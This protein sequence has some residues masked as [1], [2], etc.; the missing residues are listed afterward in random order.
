VITSARPT[1]IVAL[2]DSITHA[3]QGRNSYRRDLWNQLVEAGYLIDFV[4]TQSTTQ[5]GTPFPDVTFDPDHD[6][7]WGWRTDEVLN[8]RN[9]QLE[10]G[11]LAD[12]LTHYT[13][14]AALVHLGSNDV[15][16]GNSSDGT[17]E[18]LRQVIQTLRA[19][20]PKVV[21]FLA[22]IIPSLN[23]DQTISS[24]TR[25]ER[26]IELNNLIP[27]LVESENSAESPVILVDQ[28]TG[29][30]AITDTYDGI[31]PNEV[32]EAKM[33]ANW[34]AALS[35]Y[36]DSLE[37]LSGLTIYVDRRGVVV[38]N[39]F[40]AGQLYSGTLTSNTDGTANPD[41]VIRG[42][43]GDDII[44]GGM[45]GNDIIDAGDG[46]N[47]IDY[48]KGTNTIT[49]GDG[50]NT[51]Y[52]SSGGGRL[53]IELGEGNNVIEF[54]KGTNTITAGDGDN[55][56]YSS[57]GGGG[58]LT[59]ELGEGNNVIEFGKGNNMITAG[60]GDNT[61]YSSSGGGRLT[62]ELGE[63]SN[64][65]DFSKGN[66]MITAGDGDN[67]VY[68]SSGGGGRLSIELGDGD[69]DIDYG[70]GNNTITAGDGDN[71]V[72]SSNGGGGRLSIELGEG[73]ND[74]QLSTRNAD[75]VIGGG[76]NTV[77]LGRGR[78]IVRTGNGD[79]VINM[80]DD[81]T[82]AGRKFVY[83]GDGD[84]YI[85]VGSR[86]DKI[87][88]GGGNNTL[89][90]GAGRD[91]FRLSLDSYNYLGDFSVADDRLRI[92]GFNPDLAVIEQGTGSLA[93][94]TFIRQGDSFVAQLANTDAHVVGGLNLS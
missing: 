78:D 69:N 30:D 18:E 86:M 90:G 42:T 36:F 41:D 72:Y 45:L 6:A 92:K 5:K 38:G 67:T 89:F 34:F 37:D 63:G 77:T 21:I 43:A 44:S 1:G 13:P 85:A 12:W 84:D 49:A 83:T 71:T 56:V 10:E 31:H 62:V 27:G 47:D 14:D 26:I 32:G 91:L 52:S 94:D 48:G 2:G 61:V 81:I 3:D 55:T 58:R 70:K 54:G 53:T 57:S 65:V 22:Q 51:V 35:A 88:P 25:N 29:F 23:T 33:A 79:N 7:R 15:F 74:I 28:F 16:Q 80:E 46:N 76:A 87:C 8:G 9:S 11:K 93:A 75:I 60:D 73:N 17:I 20:N 24:Q 64:D 66:N 40:E 4:G 19:D 50:D 59:I 82:G 39:A 68:S